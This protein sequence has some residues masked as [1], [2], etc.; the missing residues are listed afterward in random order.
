MKKITC[1]TCP[2]GCEI[3]VT[4]DNVNH[5]FEGAQCRLGEEYALSEISCPVRT[6]TTSVRIKSSVMPLLSVRTTAPVPK[7]L[8]TDVLRQAL[9]AD[10]SPPV[11][12]GDVII[13]NVCGSGTDLAATRSIEK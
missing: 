12:I 6:V 4:G 2:L 7:N 3:S 13:K 8:I 11:R 5:I 10:I 9:D 1:I